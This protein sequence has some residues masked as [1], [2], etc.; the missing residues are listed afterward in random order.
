MKVGEVVSIATPGGPLSLP[1][2]GIIQDWS[3][4]QGSVFLDRAAVR[5]A[6]G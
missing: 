1:I 5:E 4:Q 6:L 2:V 3:D